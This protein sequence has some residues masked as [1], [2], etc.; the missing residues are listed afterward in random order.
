MNIIKK[1]YGL[2]FGIAVTMHLAIIALFGLNLTSDSELVK[3][4]TVPEIIQASILD[5][6]KIQQEADRLKAKEKNKQSK[7]LKQQKK[8]EN[9]RKKEQQLLLNAKKKRLQEEKKAKV[10]KQ[11]AKELE[12]KN[13]QLAIKEKQKVEKIKQQKTLEA[14]RLAK[15]KAENL[16]E[17]KRLDDLR[18]AEEEKQQVLLARQQAEAAKK[19]AAEKAKAAAEKAKAEH[20]RQATITATTAIQRKV[21]NRWIRPLSSIK[22]LNCT[23][24]VKLLPSG[25][26]MNASVVRSS[27]DSIFDRSAENAVRKASPLPVPKDRALFTK[28]YRSFTFEFK[29]E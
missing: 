4:K 18:H 21:N 10:L 23:I 26:V 11:K 1:K 2:S 20:N 22:G 15:I 5:D 29:P 24:R 7:N 19:A 8:L 25:D 3:Q 28:K 12:K 6:D 27:G 16:A 13:K 17:K 9:N 14:K